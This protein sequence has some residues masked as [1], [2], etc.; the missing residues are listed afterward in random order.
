MAPDVPFEVTASEQTARAARES[1]H[2]QKT[3]GRLDIIFLIVAAVVSI[4]VLGQ[5]SSFGS[6]TF[7]WALVLAAFFLVPYGLIFAEIGSTFTDEGGVYVWVRRAF[8]RPMAAIASLL[9]WVT[10]PVWVGGSCTFIASE[11]WSQYVASFE[12]GSLTDYVFKVVF[13]WLTV[14]AA[15]I[16][17]KHGKWIPNDTSGTRPLVVA[18]RS[19]KDCIVESDASASSF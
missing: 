11:V 10:Q 9:T 15:V 4:E 3:L 17:L 8:G 12:H 7:T 19:G 2:L 14:L 13:V 16:S 18:N 5:V 1:K 6:Q